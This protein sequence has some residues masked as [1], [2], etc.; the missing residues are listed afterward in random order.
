MSV[1]STYLS[2]RSEEQSRRHRYDLVRCAHRELGD[3]LGAWRLVSRRSIA[4]F[5]FSFENG[6][7]VECLLAKTI[8]FMGCV[9]YILKR[10]GVIPPPRRVD[11]VIDPFCF[12]EI[13]NENV[14]CCFKCFESVRKK[15]NILS[16]AVSMRLSSWAVVS[17][18]SYCHRDIFCLKLLSKK[19]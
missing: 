3:G 15:F 11:T 1:K 2:E 19:E 5:H 10:V 18:G 8:V 17:S 9:L 14:F 16:L 6:K 12:F 7:E 4:R 13:W